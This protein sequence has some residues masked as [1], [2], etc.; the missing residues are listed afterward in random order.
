ME[1]F[2][3]GLNLACARVANGKYC[4]RTEINDI[5]RQN[6]GTPL[7]QKCSNS[8]SY[9]SHEKHTWQYFNFTSETIPFLLL[10]YIPKQLLFVR[11]TFTCIHVLFGYI[12]FFI[13]R[14]YLYIYLSIIYYYYVHHDHYGNDMKVFAAIIAALRASLLFI[15]SILP[16]F[17]LLLLHKDFITILQKMDLK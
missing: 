12:H 8:Q 5:F 7:T 4:K 1:V 11:L 16:K 9:F 6:C 14:D 2:C 17:V 3:N 15:C 10:E 13:L